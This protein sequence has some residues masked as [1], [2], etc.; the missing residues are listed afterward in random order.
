MTESLEDRVRRLEHQ[1]ASLVIYAKTLQKAINVVQSADATGNRNPR[2]YT[3]LIE[4]M[5]KIEQA[6]K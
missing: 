3:I 5:G 2:S 4:E 6:F 1:V